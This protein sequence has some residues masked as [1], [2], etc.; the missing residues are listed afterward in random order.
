M[1][2]KFA[3]HCCLLVALAATT[4]L[5]QTH[6]KKQRSREPATVQQ[7]GRT[8]QQLA[9][10]GFIQNTYEGLNQNDE[11]ARHTQPTNP[12]SNK[13]YT[14]V[15]QMPTLNGQGVYQASIAAINQYLVVPPTAPKGRVFVKFEVRKDVRVSHAQIVKGLRADLDSAVLVATRQLPQFTPGKQNGKAVVVSLTLPVTVPVRKQP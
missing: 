12:D 10:E 6:P 5:A 8:R 9:E 7:A 3:G 15:E 2:M 14:Y 4:A 11:I 1:T 13:V